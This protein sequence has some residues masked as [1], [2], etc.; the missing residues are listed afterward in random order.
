ML[1]GRS[2]VGI[3]SV[4]SCIFQPD[5]LLHPLLA[6]DPMGRLGLCQYSGHT[7]QRYCAL[8]W[9]VSLCGEIGREIASLSSTVETELC[10]FL[11]F[12]SLNFYS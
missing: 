12:S 11:F 4:T 10:I 9:K 2:R 6:V 1:V 3:T 5:R 8:I 7:F